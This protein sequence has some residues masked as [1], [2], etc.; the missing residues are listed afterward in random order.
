MPLTLWIWYNLWTLYICLL[1]KKNNI[2]IFLK[3]KIHKFCS[4]MH[5]L[6]L[7]I[8]KKKFHQ[9]HYK[10]HR[11]RVRV[12]VFNTTFNNISVTSWQSVLVEKT[13]DL[14]QVTD[15]LYHIKLYSVH[16]AMSGIRTRA[17]IA[18]VVAIP[19]TI[20]SRS[21]PWRPPKIIKDRDN[22]QYNV[23]DTPNVL[24]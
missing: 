2:L 24:W 9:S 4:I 15:K 19:T 17:L 8:L 3:Q 1:Y 23:P 21:R 20:R 22:N 6:F 12:I 11:V 5:V 10:N 13:T 16:L 7:N 14:L 18:Q